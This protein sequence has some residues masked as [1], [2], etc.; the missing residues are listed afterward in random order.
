[1]NDISKTDDVH[2]DHLRLFAH[3]AK[4]G[5]LTE[6]S[7]NQGL[8]QSAA[9]QAIAQ[10]EAELQV[11]LLDRSRRPLVLTETGRRFQKGVETLLNDWDRLQAYVRP[12]GDGGLTGTISVA[13][14]YSVG[15]HLLSSLIQRFA[16]RHPAVRVRMQYLRPDMVVQAVRDK[17]VDLG[18]LSFPVA[19]RTLE[20][21]PLRDEPLVAVCHPAHRLVPRRRIAMADLAGQRLIAFDRDLPIRRAID[22][23]LRV[24]KV[25][26][27]VAMEFDNIESIK[28][29]VLSGFGLAIL[30][31]PT[32]VREVVS[33]LLVALP[34]TGVTLTRPV[35]LI[36]R[37]RS[38]PDAAIEGFIAFLVA[39]VGEEHPGA[40][41]AP[42]APL[43][44]GQTPS[45][46]E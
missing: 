1:M 20:S 27:D 29:A 46:W 37:R 26:V 6:G 24:A 10:I 36:R 22:E 17:K 38:A 23:A 7:R 45:P 13:A 31:E 25:K 41:T 39:S 42:V 43:R 34:I 4:T 35:G 3:V 18:I 32:V 8:S 9:S 11:L 40:A 33:R 12:A 19:T 44:Y 21:I 15:I 2:L 14:I 30:P 28:Q 16:T 5:S